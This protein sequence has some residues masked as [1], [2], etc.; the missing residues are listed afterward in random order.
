MSPQFQD[1]DILVSASGNPLVEHLPSPWRVPKE[2]WYGFDSDVSDKGYT[3]LLSLDEN[4]YDPNDSGMDGGHPIT[5]QHPI[6][7][8]RAFYTA[9]GHQGATYAIPGFKDLIEKAMR[10]AGD[11][12]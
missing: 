10:W 9:I 6:G 5:W 1:A 2:E 12:D 7:K 11:L 8:G 4:S 3:V